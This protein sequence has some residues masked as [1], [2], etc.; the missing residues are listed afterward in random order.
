MDQ[1]NTAAFEF[2]YADAYRWTAGDCPEYAGAFKDAGMAV[3]QALN[4]L[5][6]H[7]AK[8]AESKFLSAEGAAK[9]LA[10]H[11]ERVVAEAT[12]Q[13]RAVSTAAAELDAAEH[14]LFLPPALEPGDAVGASNDVQIRWWFDNL[15]P[16]E[17]STVAAEVQKGEHRDLV[18][19]LA[20]SPVPGKAKAFGQTYWRGIVE[21][22]SG[23]KVRE[24]ETRRRVKAWAEGVLNVAPRVALSKPWS[25]K[26]VEGPLERLTRARSFMKPTSTA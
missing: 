23:H 2:V 21:K 8:F 25:D 22:E 13:R 7:T 26:P 18:L 9:L 4:D 5:H 15:S 24:I 16:N 17:L 14:R 10:P 3:V 11:Q 1:A 20:R 6:N 12:R 19:A